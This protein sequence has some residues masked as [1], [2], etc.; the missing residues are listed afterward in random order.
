MITH[1]LGTSTEIGS[2]TAAKDRRGTHPNKKKVNKNPIIEHIRSFNP[3]I[4][5]Y[6][7]AHAPNRLYL[8]SDVTNIKLMH[9]DYLTTDSTKCGYEVYRKEVKKLNISFAVLGN[10]ECEQCMTAGVHETEN[11]S[12]KS[13]DSCKECQ[14]QEVHLRKAKEAREAYQKDKD[15]PKTEGVVAVSADLQKVIML[16]RIPGVKSVLF[17]KR[18]IAFNETFAHVGEQDRKLKRKHFLALW[19]ETV[20]GRKAEDICS[21]FWQFLKQNRD[22]EEIIVW[23]DNCSAQNKNWTFFTMMIVAVNRLTSAQ[24]ITVKYFEAGRTFMSADSVH[25]GIEQEMKK[26]GKIF[27]WEDFVKMATKS[28]SGRVEVL[29][30]KIA[31]FKPWLDKTSKAKILRFRPRLYLRDIAVAEFR[32]GEKHLY[33]KKSHMEEEFLSANILQETFD[34]KEP[35]DCTQARGIS[36]QKKVS[37]LRMLGPLMP[38]NRRVSWEDMEETEEPDSEED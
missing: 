20:K 3:A 33:Y 2:A 37:I 12:G 19:N 5:H 25:H 29:D 38:S 32:Q 21:T 26:V 36:R 14:K 28:N 27:D 17:T 22:A 15:A 9:D 18:I 34:L 7:R 4:G 16:P 23:V 11:H 6:R 1:K 24:R 10:E 13:L 31:D 8:P 30:M 35:A